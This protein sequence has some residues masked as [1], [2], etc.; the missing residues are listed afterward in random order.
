[1]SKPARTVILL[2]GGPAL[3][4]YFGPL[5]AA[6]REDFHV[7]AYV[8]DGTSI[9]ALV[10][11]LEARV[12]DAAKR[13]GA[14]PILIGHSWGATLA[15]F[16]ASMQ[17]K[18]P[19]LLPKKIVLLGAAPL[20]TKTKARFRANLDARI[21]PAVREALD[22]IDAEYEATTD[23][24]EQSRLRRMNLD[25]ITPFYNVVPESTKRLPEPAWNYDAFERIWDDLNAR[26]ENGTIP[27]TLARITVP[28]VS[29]HGAD[30]PIPVEPT[31]TFL[32][33]NLAQY[34]ANTYFRAGHFAWVEPDGIGK[35]FLADLRAELQ[36]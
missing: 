23:A 4:G 5:E 20:E 2:H 26:L 33:A 7:D 6:L 30:D 18:K 24:A 14:P 21:P 3:S 9:A 29:F 16:Y 35:R 32:R 17:A 27:E 10:R 25:L 22:R 19:A 13:D 15:L 34:R 1:M 8:Q 28:V 11:Q 36:R 12:R 31:H